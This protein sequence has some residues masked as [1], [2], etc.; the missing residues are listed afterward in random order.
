[1]IT[2]E[3]H[4][5]DIPLIERA[6]C[7]YEQE[8]HASGMLDGVMSAILGGGAKSKEEREAQINAARAKAEKS[9]MDRRLACSRIRVRL[10][11]AQQRPGE[12]SSAPKDPAA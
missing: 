12:F 5:S 7:L 4:E 6:L 1:M 8:P 9:A 10:L 3:I 11:E 2:I